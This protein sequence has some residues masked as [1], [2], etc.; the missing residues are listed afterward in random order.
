M[1]GRSSLGPPRGLPTGAVALERELR[2]GAALG[3]GALPLY[4]RRVPRLEEP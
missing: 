1:D 2:A 4:L 3:A